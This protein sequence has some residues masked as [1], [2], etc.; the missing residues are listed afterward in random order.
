MSISKEDAQRLILEPA[1]LEALDSLGFCIGPYG[2]KVGFAFQQRRALNVIYAAKAADKLKDGSSIAILGGGLAGAMACIGLA[3]MGHMAQIFEARDRVL[4][5]QRHAG[6][7]VLHPCYNSWPLVD[8][9]SASTDHPF[10]NWYVGT[11]DHVMATL[12][13]EWN[14]IYQPILPEP[15]TLCTVKD[16]RLRDPERNCVVVSYEEK[17]ADGSVESHVDEFDTAIVALGFGEER[18]LELSDELS[19]W[20]S[21]QLDHLRDNHSDETFFVSGIGDGGLIDCLRLLHKKIDR[22]ELLIRVISYVRHNKYSKPPAASSPPEVFELSDIERRI[23]ILEKSVED[24]F[25]RAASDRSRTTSKFG[26]LLENEISRILAEGYRKIVKLLPSECK[27]MLDRS[28]HLPERVKLIGSLE[29]PFTPTT[30]PINKLLLAHAINEHP[31]IY[32]RARLE[33][34]NRK[35][36]L[37]LPDNSFTALTA[38]RK[39]VRHGTIAPIKEL[40]DTYDVEKARSNHTLSSVVDIALPAGSF[41]EQLPNAVFDRP[42]NEEFLNARMQKAKSFAR[43]VLKTTISKDWQPELEPPGRFVVALNEEYEASAGRT[44]GF[45][46]FLFGV[47]LISEEEGEYEPAVGRAA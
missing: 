44:G 34:R 9:F 2:D 13:S 18:D 23:R 37:R 19:Y 39:V 15:K 33:K 29:T 45:D 26:S 25:R 7:R 31:E 14:T 35:P 21:D 6:H 46:R 28:L 38:D 10:L 12:L 40:F 24:K 11:A 1:R 43:N 5:L 32:V 42:E 3:G 41:S 20:H 16:V 4:T 36:I 47:P 8:E 22:G 30:A 17:K 27:R